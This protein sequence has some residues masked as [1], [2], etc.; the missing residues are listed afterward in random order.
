MTRRF[1]PLAPR[2]GAGG[3]G[4]PDPGTGPDPQ[5]G[6]SF[7]AGFAGL[8]GKP[9]AGKSTLMNAL[10]GQKLSIV[11]PKPQTTRDRILGILTTPLA[12]AVFVD[13]PGIIDPHDAFNT[14][15]M[16]IA[17]E[18][19][20]GVDLIL[21]V[22]DV[23]DPE[24][25]PPEVAEPLLRSRVP[26]ILVYTH[27][28][29][30]APHQEP[31]PL[32]TALD[33]RYVAKVAVSGTEGFG[34]V[35]LVDEITKLLPLSPA[36]Y[37]GDTVTDRN[38]RYLAGELVREQAFLALEQEVPY[39]VACEVEEFRE[40]DGPQ[41]V[42]IRVTVLVE[43]DTQKKILIGAAGRTLK[44]ISSNARGEI[45]KLLDQRVYLD[46]WVKVREHWR[47][48]RGDLK[49]LGYW[50]EAKERERQRQATYYQSH[51]SQCA[52][53]PTETDKPPETE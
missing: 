22:V 44:M 24:P 2:G 50:S 16:D 9:N 48:N 39:C 52:K 36:L 41:P 34:L 51:G 25:A 3:P 8:L 29:L 15:L 26:A 37:D 30:L 33:P 31:V 17:A 12:Q 49:R 42:Y 10:V 6:S 19:L 32:P 1:K 18:A 4:S 28:D 46:I 40:S 47:R 11:T 53:K 35:A 13:M 5:P 43:R 20:E 38:L 7:R 14:A 27:C 23:R 21:H 45:E